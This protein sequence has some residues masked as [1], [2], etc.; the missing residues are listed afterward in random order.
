MRSS[1]TK[2]QPFDTIPNGIIIKEMVFLMDGD[3][4]C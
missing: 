3:S 1:T 2:K 4:L